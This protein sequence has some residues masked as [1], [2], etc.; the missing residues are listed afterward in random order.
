LLTN[1]EGMGALPALVL[2]KQPELPRSGGGSMPTL[3]TV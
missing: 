1:R 2:F 3:R